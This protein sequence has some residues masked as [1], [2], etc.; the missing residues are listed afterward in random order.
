MK[1]R[2]PLISAVL[3]AA[4]LAS[5][6]SPSFHAD[7]AKR[8]DELE[9]ARGPEAYAALRRIWSSWDRAS[10]A[11]VEETLEHAATD[12]RL[13]PPVRTYAGALAAFARFRR[14]DIKA[15]HD[16][17]AALGFVD[18][19]LVIGPFDNEGKSGLDTTFGPELAFESPIVPG[20]AESGKERPVRWRAIP[21]EFPQ[22][23]VSFGS[24]LRPE[25][26]VCAYATTFVESR[27]GR[28]EP[29]KISAWI[30]SGGAFKVFWNGEE[31]LESSVYSSHDFDRYAVP[32]TL[33][34]G[35]NGLTVKICGEE[36]APVLSVR[37][38]D[39]KG[40]PDPDLV[41]TNDVAAS[42]PAAETAARLA[43][44]KKQHTPK[45]KPASAKA[46]KP[47]LEKLKLDKPIGDTTPADKDA[48]ATAARP[49]AKPAVL[50]KPGSVEGPVQTFERLTARDP[51]AANLE[52]YARYL[53][54]TDG[55]DPA[56]HRAR[57]LA[58]K[59]SDKA[60]TVRRLL[61]AAALAEDHNQRGDWITKAEALDSR[62]NPSREVL[63]ARA[64]HRR[65]S[66]S[67]EEAFPIFE[68]LIKRDPDDVVAVQGRV[69]LYAMA[70]LPRTALATLDAALARNPHAVN[71]L[72][73]YASTLRSLGRTTEASEVEARYSGLRFDDGG[74]LT[75][76]TALAIARR[77]RK[78]AEHWSDRLVESHPGD[79]WALNAAARAYRSLGQ[80]DRAI[81][82]YQRALEL[83][84]EDV[85]T[86]RTLA[87]LYGETGKT[88]AELVLLHEILRIKPQDKAV[89]E[90]VEHV[91]PKKARPDEAYAWAPER[92]LPLR[93]APPQGQNRRT[94]RD[95]T[96]STMF[97]NGLSS[98]YRQ[99]V[100]QPLTDS[101][102]ANARQYGF[103]YETSTQVVQLRGAKVY[104]GD[105]RVDEAVEWGEGPADDPSISMYT[106]GRAFYVQFP[107]LEAGDVVELRYR[108][109]DVTPRNEF[110]DYFGEITQL[111]SSDPTAN[112]E[113][114][115][116]TPKARTLY[117]DTDVPGLTPTV[118]EA[119]TQRT[120]RFFAESVP[121]LDPE[122]A[123]PPGPEVLGFVHV[124]TYKTWGDLGRW[125]WGLVKDQFDVDEDT[126]K[127]ARKITEGKKTERE[128]VE[129]VY[130]W[131]IR[132]T[133]YV[134]LEFGIYGYKPHRCVQTV[135]RGWGDCKDKATVITTLLNE[136][137][138][139][140]T[141]VVLRTQMKGGLRSKVASFA[142]F[143]HAIAY[144]PSMNLYLDG[145]AEHTG[146][147]ELPRMDLGAVG[148][149]VNQGKS[150]LIQIPL[151]PPDKNYVAREVHAKVVK[152]GDTK[153]TLDYST[154]GYTSA[155]LRR[156][157]HAESARRDRINHDIGGELPG[158]VIAPGAQGLTTSDLDDNKQPVRIHLE[159]TAPTFAR[160]EGGQ[161]SMAVTNSF[162]LTPAYASLS[163]RR[164]DVWLLS[165]AELRDS[166]VV[167]LPAGAKVVALPENVNLD[168]PFGWVKMT[169]EKQGDRVTVTSRV[170]L[171]TDR[172]V[173][174]DYPAFKRFCE[175]ADRALSRRLVVEP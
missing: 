150:E 106:T 147:D 76:M 108:V 126:R 67:Y 140:A 61:L 107:R 104:R 31:V 88:D 155:E 35:K 55:D 174:K 141:M 143:D 65:E 135:T 80:S 10:P 72:N 24:L 121:G 164:Q 37:L 149:R 8:Q 169:V 109:D 70:G 34:P 95:L 32:L 56:V 68:R 129:A 43:K 42:A 122:P 102:A 58:V 50:A 157:Y 142:P 44:A 145:T 12:K 172:V 100:F 66:P 6:Q 98:Q 96:V 166:F 171:R 87:D 15:A 23:F 82:T 120:Y 73:L 14:G 57:D 152:A 62:T 18:R 83:A 168:N 77:D 91:E 103:V 22:G 118:T 85:G 92:F 138:I 54:E 48:P 9:S 51:S 112:A 11:Q 161:L 69:E 4:G 29:R 137:G 33:E 170:G 167:E 160:R 36:S 130:D 49:P 158:F 90:Y 136:L 132:N 41:A 40:A 79:L 119:G 162:R 16:Q 127:L 84:P 125:Y 123:M 128:K 3:L 64:L 30:G 2:S 5:A 93:H 86:L 47:K 139:P 94:L 21:R 52:Q 75:Q 46:D 59:A 19:F 38:A 74:F 124:S 89:R 25:Q 105:G 131:V 115:V 144:V 175:D 7:L 1:H 154:A 113:Y 81:A 99:I 60:P 13:T 153:L 63:L 159:G 173:P 114:V 151:P 26:K 165:P 45:A 163:Q 78:A 146:I 133:R 156:Q 39:E 116:V 20:K 134:A 148:F 53:Y 71:L 28:K 17:I 27:S 111:Q 117:F 97:E 101:A 110:N